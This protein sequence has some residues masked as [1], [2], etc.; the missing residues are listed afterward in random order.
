MEISK[1]FKVENENS[2]RVKFENLTVDVGLNFQ[3]IKFLMLKIFPIFNIENL[4]DFLHWKF[5]RFSNLENMTD[6]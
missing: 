3:C 6:L 5:D 4:T 1:F 2:K